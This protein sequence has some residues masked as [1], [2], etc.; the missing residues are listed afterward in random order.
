[1]VK[2]I[3]TNPKYQARKARRSMRC[4]CSLQNR[5]HRC[6]RSIAEGSTYVAK[7]ALDERG[8]WLWDIRRYCDHCAL[9]NLACVKLSEAE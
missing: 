7:V 4:F 8:L 9:K 2:L 6:T 3:S 1:M 5:S